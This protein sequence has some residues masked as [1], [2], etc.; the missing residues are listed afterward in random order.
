MAPACFKFIFHLPNRLLLDDA[1]KSFGAI[2]KKLNLRYRSETNWNPYG[3]VSNGSEY[4]WEL[5]FSLTLQGRQ[6]K[7]HLETIRH[8]IMTAVPEFETSHPEL[9]T[10]TICRNVIDYPGLCQLTSDWWQ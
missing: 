7:N 10:V 3:S 5:E 9:G 4:H 1:R 2:L 6:I 8:L